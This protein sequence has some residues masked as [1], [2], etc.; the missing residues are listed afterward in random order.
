[1]RNDLLP[2]DRTIRR[3]SKK[4]RLTMTACAFFAVAVFLSEQGH[5]WWSVVPLLGF[6]H[7]YLM[8]VKMDID[9]D[10]EESKENLR[11]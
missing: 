1:M 8:T 4:I 9:D 5:Y 10:E 3:E 6:L 11:Q 7:E 2:R